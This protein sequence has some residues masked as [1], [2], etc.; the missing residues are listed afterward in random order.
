MEKCKYEI[1]THHERLVNY[2]ANVSTQK[3][4]IYL[5]PYNANEHRVAGGINTQI[6]KHRRKY[7]TTRKTV[8]WSYDART[9]RVW[10]VHGK[11]QTAA[12]YK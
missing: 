4:A 12:F 9:R 8:W 5:Q 11:T 3:T 6:R 1:Q 7:E 10:F 2:K